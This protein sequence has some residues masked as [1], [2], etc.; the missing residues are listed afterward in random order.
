MTYPVRI[1]DRL[2]PIGIYKLEPKNRSSKVDRDENGEVK[3]QN[4]G[5]QR[6]FRLPDSLDEKL[7]EIIENSGLSGSEYV[8][9]VMVR[10]LSKK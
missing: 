4:L 5:K 2:K 3:S 8:R 10:H 9:E 6:I 7:D 1:C